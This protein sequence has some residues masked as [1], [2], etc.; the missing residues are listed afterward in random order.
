VREIVF[1]RRFERDFRRLKRTIPPHALDY[2]T[3]EYVLELLQAGKALPEA[4]REHSLGGDFAGF[5]E[6]H[7]DPDWLLIYRSLHHRVVLHRTGT[8]RDLFRARRKSG[9]I[10]P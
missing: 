8:H 4:F 1:T 2:E 5:T 9:K 6:C 7:M 10:G 3:L